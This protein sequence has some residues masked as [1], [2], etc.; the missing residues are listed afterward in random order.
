M[1]LRMTE[2]PGPVPSCNRG[3]L[4]HRDRTF[5][6]SVPTDRDPDPASQH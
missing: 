3:T 1:L 4:P 2:P 5:L 6:H